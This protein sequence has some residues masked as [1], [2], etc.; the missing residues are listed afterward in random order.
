MHIITSTVIITKEGEIMRCGSKCFVVQYEL[1]G[2]TKRDYITTRTPAEARKVLRQ[3]TEGKATSIIV[4][5][6]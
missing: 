2:E 3:Q 6:K 1:D 5:K 4:R